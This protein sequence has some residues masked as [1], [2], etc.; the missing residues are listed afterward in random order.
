LGAGV[1]EGGGRGI[2]LALQ[3]AVEGREVGEGAAQGCA[4]RRDRVEHGRA[5]DIGARGAQ[6]NAGTLDAERVLVEASAS[7][8]EFACGQL[9][10]QV[11]QPQ[12]AGERESLAHALTPSPAT[13]RSRRCH[14]SSAVAR[15]PIDCCRNAL[16]DASWS[17]AASTSGLLPRW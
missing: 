14:D 12:K 17:T 5:R 6:R 3:L 4:P 9:L 7:A 15:S 16:M 8:R 10:L 11:A 13:R 2:R 1:G